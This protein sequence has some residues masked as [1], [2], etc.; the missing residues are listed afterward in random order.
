[1]N[2]KTRSEEETITRVVV[3]MNATMIG[4]VLGFLCGIAL[5]L[6]TNWLV[7][8][9]GPNPGAHLGLLSQYFPGYD[10]TFVGSLIGFVYAFLAGFLSGAIL[11]AVYNK[12]A[13]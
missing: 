10:V 3:R 2:V 9:D 13:K 11:G 12:L 7:L 6:A 8:K 4:L 1:L 5:F